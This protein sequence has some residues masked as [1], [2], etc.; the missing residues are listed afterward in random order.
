MLVL[1]LAMAALTVARTG[2]TLMAPAVLVGVAQALV[3]PSSL[4]LVSTRV[5]DGHI[6]VGMGLVGAMRNA[7]KV[8]GPVLAGLL[9]HWMDFGSTFRLIGLALLSGG[10][11][12]WLRA[13]G[14]RRPAR[15]DKMVPVSS[16]DR[17]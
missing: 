8:A 17:A 12:V 15:R 2:P 10:V 1:G 7:G 5:A 16:S 11:L 14:W 6:G 9:I 13:Q 4:A 3:S